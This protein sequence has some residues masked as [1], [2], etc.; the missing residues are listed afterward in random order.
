MYGGVYM[1]PSDLIVENVLVAFVDT[2]AID[3]MYNDFSA[4]EHQFAALK[5]HIESK[6]LILLTHEIAVRE[7]ERHI[8]EEVPK[9]LDKLASVQKSKELVLLQ[10]IRRYN[11]LFSSV[12]TEKVI[13]DTIKALKAKL[14]EIGVLILKTGNISVK[15]LMEDYFSSTPPFGQKKKKAEFPDAIMLQSLI[16]AVGDNHKIHIVASDG[17]WDGV[18]KSQP[19][20]VIHKH[21]GSLLDY[22]NK[23]NVASSAI[24]AFLSDAATVALI[25]TRLNQ[26]VKSI[27][28]QVDGLTYDR[29]GL[30]EGYSYDEIELL[31]VSDIAYT[32]HTIE[33]I[34]CSNIQEDNTITAIVTIVGSAR[35]K[36]NCSYFDE[37]N[38]VWDSEDH[39][40]AYKE[41]GKATEIHEVL[42][43]V[44]LTLT[45]D[46]KEKLHVAECTLIQ[47]DDLTSLDNDTLVDREYI[48][49]YYDPGFCVERILRCLHCNRDIKVDLMS[50]ETDCVSASERQMGYEREYEVNV[51][52][53]CPHCGEEYQ[54]T[55]QIWEYPENC[56]NLEQNIIICKKE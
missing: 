25:S 29:K 48:S 35:A 46:Y 7:M 31:N 23:G 5:K 4:M 50:D 20:Y 49:D 42:F 1:I 33:D 19:N 47:T 9:Q 10:S 32:I 56:C 6:K 8:R 2:S 43:P 37:A 27:D 14:K 18:C 40:Y 24:K 3:P 53:Y 28:F 11:T 36:F 13:A 12:A 44:R 51:S 38:S 34:E 39:E 22:I 15:S 54:V 45:G 55:G 30:V 21:I 41:Y 16:R 26:I 52:G 17:D